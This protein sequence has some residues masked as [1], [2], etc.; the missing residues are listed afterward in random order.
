MCVMAFSSD[1]QYWGIQAS[2]IMYW[3]GKLRITVEGKIKEKQLNRDKKLK[4]KAH[5]LEKI[6]G[7]RRPKLRSW[8]RL[9][10]VKVKVK[11]RSSMKG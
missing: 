11:G 8:S 1:L 10:H 7:F 5:Q 2:N 9:R 4:E 3:E 6:I